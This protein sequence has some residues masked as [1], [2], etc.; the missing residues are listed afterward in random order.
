V[1]EDKIHDAQCQS[2]ERKSLIS[3]IHHPNQIGWQE[4]SYQIAVQQVFER[5]ERLGKHQTSF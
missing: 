5:Y 1:H 3:H 2:F 4:F